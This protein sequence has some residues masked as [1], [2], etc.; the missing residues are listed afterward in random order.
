MRRI[1]RRRS[2]VNSKNVFIGLF[3]SSL[4]GALLLVG[5][6]THRSAS[7]AV[8]DLDNQGVGFTCSTDGRG[9]IP[10]HHVWGGDAASQID[11]TLYHVPSDGSGGGVQWQLGAYDPVTEKY[12]VKGT[13]APF[14]DGGLVG[15]DGTPLI[16]AS[17]FA[18]KGSL[19]Q[20]NGQVMDPY[21][22]VYVAIMPKKSSD[23]AFYVQLLP[24]ND[25]DGLGEMR[26]IANLGSVNN[27][28]GGTY[29]EEDG[30]PYALVSN[31][32]LGSSTHKIPLIRPDG[33]DV[34][35]ISKKGWK[36][37]GVPK[38]YSWVKEGIEYGEKV[39]NLVALEQTG[40]NVGTIWLGSSTDALNTGS[41]PDVD[42][43]PIA[44]T[45]VTLPTTDEDDEEFGASYNYKFED[46]KTFLYFSA[47]KAGKLVK[48]T[49]PDETNDDDNIKVV[50]AGSFI[51]EDIGKTEASS[52]N[53]GA[54]C[55]YEPPPVIGELVASTWPPDC[56]TDFA[57][58][59]GSTVPIFVHNRTAATV[60]VKITATVAGATVAEDT[61]TSTGDA[62]KP[63]ALDGT[64]LFAI[65]SGES[66]KLTIPILKDQVWAASVKTDTG[67][68]LEM[69]PSGGTLNAASCDEE[70]PVDTYDPL[71]TFG[72][73]TAD[74]NG[75]GTN[76]AATV[77]NS[78]SSM[79]VEVSWTVNGVGPMGTQNVAAEDAAHNFSISSSQGDA[80]VVTVSAT[81][82]SNKTFS[83]T[84]TGCPEASTIEAFDCVNHSGLIQFK[85][86]A[87]QD[88]YEAVV[89]DPT[90]GSYEVIYTLLNTAPQ[91][92]AT[93]NGA[94]AWA[95]GTAIH[96]T[97][98]VAYG[99]MVHDT[100][101]TKR[102]LVRFD[103]ENVEYLFQLELV[104]SAGTFDAAGNFYWHQ[105]T[106]A[107]NYP[108]NLHRI[109]AAD[110]NTAQGFADRDD[111]PAMLTA[112]D[113]ALGGDND[114]TWAA[115][116]A[117]ITYVEADL[118]AG[119][120][121]YILGLGAKLSITDVAAATKYEFPNLRFVNG[122]T[123]GQTA[124]GAAYTVVDTAGNQT[125]YFSSN[126]NGAA[127]PVLDG[128]IAALDLS[129]INLSNQNQT[130]K[131]NNAGPIPHSS[132][133]DGM[134]CPVTVVNT[135]TNFGSVHGHVW[136]DFNDDG[137]RTSKEDGKEPHVTGYSVTFANVTEYLD[138]S[139][140][141]VHKPGA[142]TYPDTDTTYTGNDDGDYRWNG[143]LPCKDNSGNA[144]QWAAYFDYTGTTWPSGFTPTGY[145][146]ETGTAGTEAAE[147]VDSDVKQ[148]IVP[149]TSSAPFTV[150][151]DDSTHAVDAG[152][153]GDYTFNPDYAVDVNCAA[154]SVVV[155]LNNTGSKIATSYDVKVYHVDSSGVE[156]LVSGQSATQVV[157]A[158]TSAAYGTAV[159]IPAADTTL[160]F[161]I[162]GKGSL[163]GVVNG[164]RYSETILTQSVNDA[165][166]V[167]CVRVTA[168][169]DCGA[170][171]E[172]VKLDNTDSN[173]IATFIVTPIVD[174]EVKT[175]ITQQVAAGALVTL[176][177]TQLGIPENSFWT[178]K[179]SAS[180]ATDGSFSERQI[181]GQLE[182]DCVEPVFNPV[183]TATAA[184]S[185]NNK[186]FV[187]Y[188]YDNSATELSGSYVAV[189]N[190]M[191]YDSHT[192]FPQLWTGVPETGWTF[193]NNMIAYPSAYNIGGVDGTLPV[194]A[195]GQIYEGTLTIDEGNVFSAVAIYG[196][197]KWLEK[198]IDS[199]ADCKDF[200]PVTT[201]DFECGVKETAVV[202]FS[203][204]NTDSEVD[205]EWKLIETN[206]AGNTTTVLEGTL[207]AG[208]EHT[209]YLSEIVDR[210]K[211]YSL[212]I[213]STDAQT[214]W[215]PA[216]EST[217]T[218]CDGEPTA[219][220][221]FA[222]LLVQCASSPPVVYLFL[223]NTH[224]DFHSQYTVN[225]FDGTDTSVAKNS[226]LSSTQKVAQG[227][228]VHYAVTIPIPD[229]GKMISV[230]VLATALAVGG[231]TITETSEIFTQIGVNCP[232]EFNVS[233]S[234]LPVCGAEAVGIFLNNTA[235][236]YDAE[237]DL[238]LFVDD[239]LSAQITVTVEAGTERQRLFRVYDGNSWY[240]RWSA[241]NPTETALYEGQSIPQTHSTDNSACPDLVLFTG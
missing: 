127:N 128:F 177:N 146:T 164:D 210:N 157:A 109:D 117:D 61:Y 129:T 119:T 23:D 97:S 15:D 3:A 125:V 63:P 44:I 86:N 107:G 7:A 151:C 207:P 235:S 131:F 139:G 19:K 171:G 240:L 165:V 35:D 179:W 154:S 219:F 201:L 168:E 241:T 180:G 89:L 12:S 27:I 72:A 21:G 11:S 85:R 8:S 144:I 159:T 51:A 220:D 38:D 32:F 124:F 153:V 118:G 2:S 13:W 83:H 40:D 103:A 91:T 232:A 116:A 58:G 221:P 122:E 62:G 53:D 36:G 92:V 29:V 18:G 34:P 20:V 142:L 59:L 208:F 162:V 95:N 126:G 14:A 209:A 49:L 230:Q 226:S 82:Q 216:I 192:L 149:Q 37:G 190:N 123:L 6:G 111:V 52:A 41:D 189:G 115:A 26:V 42:K 88:G 194:I 30:V 205:I 112:A 197:G 80:V 16:A 77:N 71:V 25:G 90:T 184:C 167:L 130:V 202:S 212:S 31:D 39:Y 65:A 60:S 176:T 104:T 218:S 57:N 138:S 225:V 94:F 9:G 73:C 45:G 98:K 198:Y 28:N 223:D 136:V 169:M 185:A 174:G 105:S 66:L 148:T 188:K 238:D 55:P 99:I 141:V 229:P 236:S 135:P 81:G 166:N 228:V 70:F 239:I 204:N 160:Y 227:S 150:T 69:I 67:D 93:S 175:A 22:N 183:V 182:K 191:L 43:G 172:Q 233:F 137:S 234:S 224:S 158:D 110:I 214:V 24:D 134:A 147:A 114:N 133:N 196:S 74:A 102:Y 120:K 152:V 78:D 231:E 113:T 163:E 217:Y 211:K 145:T 100:P 206:F 87:A 17:L 170:N 161:V 178:V 186:V 4:I 5:F 10:Y 46:G 79:P 108:R 173:Q 64:N 222:E 156:T 155:T 132:T 200:S 181:S 237:I 50:G 187:T 215:D 203:V 213:E 199:S 76:L 106:P 48:I 33:A 56:V 193:M 101:A 68:V 75:N 54:G 84:T 1:K 96:P 121:T 47:N 140:N 195:P 143:Y